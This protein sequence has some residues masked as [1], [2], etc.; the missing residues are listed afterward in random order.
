MYFKI[1]SVGYNDEF[2]VF[3]AEHEKIVDCDG[4]HKVNE[5]WVTGKVCAEYLCLPDGSISATP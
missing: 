2:A 3:I 1:F 4:V 5:T